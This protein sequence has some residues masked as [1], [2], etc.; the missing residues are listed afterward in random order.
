M[1]T[2]TRSMVSPDPHVTG[3][4]A[5]SQSVIFPFHPISIY[6]NP[7]ILKY[8]L[9]PLYINQESGNWPKTYAIHDIGSNFPNATG[10]SPS[11]C[12]ADHRILR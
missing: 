7:N 6:L 9:D 8:L 2:S 1:A 11:I 10:S 5:D 12:A 4:D 3:P